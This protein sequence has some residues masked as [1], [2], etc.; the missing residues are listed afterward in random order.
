MSAAWRGGV[1]VVCIATALGGALVA[2]CA[3]SVEGTGATDK[4]AT[5]EGGALEDGAPSES[6]DGGSGE[7][8]GNEGGAVYPD[9]GCNPLNC[10]SGCCAGDT[11]ATGDTPSQC[12]NGGLA[13]VDC[14]KQNQGC[15]NHACAIA[16]CTGCTGCCQAGSC[17]EGLSDQACGTGGNVCVNCSQQGGLACVNGLCSQ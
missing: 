3:R 13:C 12:G 6:A 4:A 11:C 10:R 17:V 15:V 14:T 16:K 7:S 1:G 5:A 2:G 8:T 9:G